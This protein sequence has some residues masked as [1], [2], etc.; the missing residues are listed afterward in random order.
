MISR[1]DHVAIA[2]RDYN[3]AFGFF[4]DI[5]GAIPGSSGED[6]SMNYYWEN[7]YL[8]DLSRL[9]LLTPTGEPSFLD[10]FLRDRDG[11]V[12]HVTMQTPD[13]DN[14]RSVLEENNIPYFGFNNYG[15]AWKELFIHPR[16]AFG[17]LIQLAE[18]DADDWIS[19]TVR[20]PRNTTYDLEQSGGGIRIRFAHP[21]G[22]C[23]RLSL[24]RDEA[25]RLLSDLS[26]AM[27]E[28]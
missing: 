26:E 19:P 17:V 12:H 21:G 28:E 22:G 8:G 13:I 10:N 18:F 20:M 27:K 5:L 4:A 15:A 6:P 1:V 2:V 11:G 16:N 14:A 9:E 24:T 7:L 25:K 23:V 3:R